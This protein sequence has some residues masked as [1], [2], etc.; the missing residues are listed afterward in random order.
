LRQIEIVLTISES[1]LLFFAGQSRILVFQRLAEGKC[2]LFKKKTNR[3]LWNFLFQVCWHLRARIGTNSGVKCNNRWWGQSRPFVTPS[4]INFIFTSQRSLEL[5]SDPWIST[6]PIIVERRRK[7]E[8]N[9]K[10]IVLKGGSS[11]RIYHLH[12]TWPKLT[13]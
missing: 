3:G 1:R 4:N 12:F 10:M 9:L 13:P 2:K 11:G 5:F 6:R 7:A 8:K